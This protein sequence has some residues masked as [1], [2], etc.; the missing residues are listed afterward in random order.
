MEN[1][2][3]VGGLGSCFSLYFVVEVCG[4]L[5]SNGALRCF[6]EERKRR[7]QHQQRMRRWTRHAITM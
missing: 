7:H 2:S 6:I 1:R 4:L 3:G 5:F